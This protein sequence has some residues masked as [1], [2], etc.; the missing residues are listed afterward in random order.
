M[1]GRLREGLARVLEHT[2]RRGVHSAALQRL[3]KTLAHL[4]IE[5]TCRITH[6][7]PDAEIIRAA[8]ELEP[9][10][11]VIG[12]QGRT[13]LSRLALGS[14]AER[15][16]ETANGSVLVVRLRESGPGG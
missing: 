6:G 1:D 4:G 3:Q 8:D 13:G 12:T 10:L 16:I 9:E 15:V 14:V 7:P 2:P 5:A 11:L